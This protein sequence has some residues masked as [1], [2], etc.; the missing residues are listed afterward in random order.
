M[1]QEIFKVVTIG[2][3]EVLRGKKRK[4]G[5]DKKDKDKDTDSEEESG[6]KRK[7]SE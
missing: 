4:K 7:R 3:D 5:N 6:V 1:A 2:G